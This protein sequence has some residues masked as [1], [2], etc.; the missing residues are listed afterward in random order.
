VSID[1]YQPLRPICTAWEGKIAAARTRKKEFQ[2][3]AD[4]CLLFFKGTKELWNERET[5]KFMKNDPGL[6]TRFRMVVAKAFEM[7]AIY[8]PALYHQNP[9]RTVTPRAKFDVPDEA[10]I[11][12][13]ADPMDPM[14]QMQQQMQMMQLQMVRGQMQQQSAQ[15]QVVANLMTAYL[16]YTPNEQSGGGLAEQAEMAI[17]EALI[18]GRGCLWTEVEYMPESDLPVVGSFWDSVDNLLIDPD[19]ETVRDAWWIA[20][21]C[22]APAWELARE[23]GVDEEVL[24]KKATYESGN[25]QG[26]TQADP[27]ERNKSGQRTNDLVRY[28]KIYSKMGLGAR[29]PGVKTELAEALET[30]FG[31]YCYLVVVPGVPY[32]L[33][34]PTLEGTD[35]ELVAAADWPIPFWRDNRWP[36]SMLDF[37][38]VP[39]DV[40]PMAPLAPGLAELRFINVMISALCGR[41]Y[42]SMRDFIAVA[43]SATEDL[44]NAI[45]HGP[46]LSIIELESL[47]S[48]INQVV[49]FLQQPQTNFDVWKILDAVI[50]MFE[51]R[52]GLTDFAYGISQQQMRSAEEVATKRDMV[53]LRP[54]AMQRKV[55]AWA[56]EQARL[57]G[58][59]ARWLV[60]AE[61]MAQIQ[62]PIAGL[63]WQQFVMTGDIERVT[64]ELEYRIE[65]GSTQRPNREKEL[66]NVNTAI[67]TW[68]PVLDGH[69]TATGDTNPL[70]K[71]I[72]EWGKKNEMDTDGLMMGPRMPPMPPMPAGPPPEEV[73]A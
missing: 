14:A 15:D 12:P 29:L 40:W 36:C 9:V 65:S 16:N 7:V 35:E 6:K 4:E 71:L 55:E 33:N 66:A 3:I 2:S 27:K 48:N 62:G 17:T 72:H 37:Y 51:R 19:A 47:N 38:P 61:H 70:N 31:D 67:Q 63:L 46:D 56:S 11:N 50:Q 43:K 25:R 73:P 41:I 13:L 64:R 28:Y 57:E 32:P 18:K 59:A 49:Q 39:R 52:T 23:Y 22:C 44:K 8:G 20:R 53:N 60:G 30:A 5:S 34:L 10:F 69:A 45:Q 24:K 54:S 1:S 42:S 68:G 58:L 21:E 26:E